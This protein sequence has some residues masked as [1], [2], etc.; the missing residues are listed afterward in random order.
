[1]DAPGP[2]R[3][4]GH[5]VKLYKLDE[6][7]AWEDNGTGLAH[8]DNL[9]ARFHTVPLLLTGSA[10]ACCIDRWQLIE[11]WLVTL[12]SGSDSSRRTPAATR[13]L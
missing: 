9:E 12:C 1:M 5:R 3:S 13:C 11:L 10:S 8:V 4:P 7:G 2:P 6:A